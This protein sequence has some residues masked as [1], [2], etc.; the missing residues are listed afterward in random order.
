M[1]SDLHELPLF[2]LSMVLFPHARV[3]LHIFEQRYRQMLRK[4]LDEGL[5]FGVVLIRSGEEVGVSPEPYMVGTTARIE[6]IFSFSDGRYD[7]TVSGAARF[8]IRSIDESLPYMVGKVEFLHEDPTE[9]EIQL[10]EVSQEARQI[11]EK[12]IRHQVEHFDMNFSVLFP[13]EPDRLSFAIANMVDISLVQ[14]QMLLETTDTTHR[15]TK[16]VEILAAH[17][18]EEPSPYRKMK[19]SDLQGWIS[20]N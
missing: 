12:V 19:P 20:S 17:C 6:D 10:Y 16:L 8:R 2:P 4:C 7:V 9:D 3:Q 15:L 18:P 1:S 11:C 13:E 5:P 14:K